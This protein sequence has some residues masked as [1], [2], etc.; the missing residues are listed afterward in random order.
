MKDKITVK[1]AGIEAEISGLTLTLYTVT[2]V[3]VLIFGL[4]AI[5][6]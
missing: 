3:C 5:N 4:V 2:A 1:F 6:I